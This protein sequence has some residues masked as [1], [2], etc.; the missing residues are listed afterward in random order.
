MGRL[1][2]NCCGKW[3][4]E[5]TGKEERGSKEGFQ[6]MVWLCG[7]EREG[8]RESQRSQCSSTKLSSMLSL[9]GSP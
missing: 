7:K 3:L 6:M 8:K 5:D 9:T 4:V 2:K 1:E